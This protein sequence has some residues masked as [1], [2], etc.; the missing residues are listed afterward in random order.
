MVVDAAP[1]RA[2]PSS[3]CRRWAATSSL[4]RGTRCAARAGSARS[5]GGRSCSRRWSRSSLGGH[6][7]RRVTARGDDLGRAAAQVRG[8]HGA[9]RRGSRARRGD[10]LPDE[11]ASRRSRRHEHELTAYALERPRRAA[12]RDVYGPPA[13]RAR[14]IVSFNIEGVH[15]HDVA[16][17]LDFEGIAIRA[18]H[19]CCQPVM[20]Q[21]RRRGDEPRELLPLHGAARRSTGWSRGCTRSSSVVRRDERIRA[22]LPRGHP[23][24]LQEPAHHGLLDPRRRARRGT[25][26]ALRRR[27]TIVACA[28]TTATRSRRSASRAAAARSARRRRRCSRSSSR[29]GRRRGRGDADGTSCSRRSASRSRRSGSSA[30]CSASAC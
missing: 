12:G 6:M 19:H 22:A 4:S 20:R 9:D 21:L 5:G 1:G 2:A 16:Q 18:G 27:G 24:P 10:R 29:A 26:P 7:I 25:E 13:E 15:P 28:S 3:T 30:R 23:R 8:R 14:G 11:S 17:I